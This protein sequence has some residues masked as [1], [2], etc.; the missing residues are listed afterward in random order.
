MQFYARNDTLGQFLEL[1]CFRESYKCPRFDCETS[2]LEHIR[3]FV[4]GSGSLYL[5]MRRI[6]EET[7]RLANIAD[8]Q[9]GP[10]SVDSVIYT[11]SWCRKCEKVSASC[12]I[13]CYELVPP[14]ISF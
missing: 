9:Q 6:P 5:I 1:Y 12:G 11:W 3:K 10:Q 14:S 8:E 7:L 2:M 13:R 4:H